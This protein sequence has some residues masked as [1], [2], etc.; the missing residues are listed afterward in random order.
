MSEIFLLGA[1]A[2]VEA[3]VPHAYK[4]SNEMLNRFS[5]ENNSRFHSFGKV[6]QFVVG[7][8]MF[9]KGIKGENPYHGVNIEDLFNAVRLLGDRQDSE[10]SPFIS[11]WHP[12]I[13][14]L[15]S[16]RMSSLTSLD[17]LEIIYGPIKRSLQEIRQEIIQQNNR[18]R[19]PTRQVDIDTFRASSQ[20]ADKFDQGVRQ[21]LSGHEGALFNATADAMIESLVEMVWVNDKD[22]VQYLVPLLRYSLEKKSSF[23]TLNYD[24]TIE[25][26]GQALGLD[27]DTG[28]DAW[29]RSSEFL[30]DDGKIPLLKLHGSIDWALSDGRTNEE[31][32]L[33][34]Q[35][36]QKIE[37][38]TSNK[39]GFHPAVVFG[40][41]NKLTAKGP[42]L[43][44]IRSFEKQ[45]E[46]TEILTAIGYSFRD[47]H[48]NEFITKWF[49]GNVSRKIR[50]INPNPE[51]FED[52]FTRALL[53][54]IAENRVEI[55]KEIASRG[56]LKILEAQ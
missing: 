20:F 43:S 55:I 26:A 33:P 30:F 44:L 49:N 16:G 54:G 11:S 37:L 18:I 6:L 47:D 50:I 22:K 42:F 12:Q 17:L 10:L 29:S 19:L 25:L 27:V 32:P 48:V 34:F 45:L 41:K 21:I 46:N 35:I 53:H 14:G 28:F 24:N 36:I 4:M 39:N 38:N 2:S 31:K 7:G 56:I 1:G 51:L 8:L 5:K 40:G 3:G 52:K 15:E 9:Q 13:V 23:V